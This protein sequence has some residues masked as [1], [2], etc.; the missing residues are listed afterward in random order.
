MSDLS[1]LFELAESDQLDL[2]DGM[3]PEELEEILEPDDIVMRDELLK[4]DDE[5]I[6]RAARRVGLLAESGYSPGHYAYS[7]ADEDVELGR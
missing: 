3:Y 1:I 2:L 4:C 7:R 5:D 6:I